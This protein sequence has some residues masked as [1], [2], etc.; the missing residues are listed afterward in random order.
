M[1]SIPKVVGRCP[2][3]DIFVRKMYSIIKRIKHPVFNKRR[4]AI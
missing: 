4:F 3:V 2:L 1:P